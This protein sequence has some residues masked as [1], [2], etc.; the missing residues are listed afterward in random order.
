MPDPLSLDGIDQIPDPAAS[1]AA[2]SATAPAPRRSRGCAPPSARLPARSAGSWDGR[3]RSSSSRGWRGPWG[4]SASAPTWARHGRELTLH[5][6]LAGRRGG[7]PRRR[8]PPP[9]PRAAGGGVRAVQHAVWI[10]P[11][12]YVIGVALVSAPGAGAAHLGEHQELPRPLHGDDGRA[13]RRG[14]PFPPPLVPFGAGLAGR[15]GRR[16]AWPPGW[17]GR[18]GSTRIARARASATSSRRTAPR[19]AWARWP[20]PRWGAS[21]GDHD[22]AKPR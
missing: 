18:S 9:R 14:R 8:P 10:V 19:S 16:A 11:A 20:A 3:R 15:C 1:V 2:S 13:P 4:S 5:R 12:A 7:R 6:R 17:P 22:P 21:E